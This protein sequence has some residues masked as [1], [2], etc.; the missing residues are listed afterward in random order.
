MRVIFVTDIFSIIEPMGVMQLSALLKAQGHETDICALEQGHTIDVIRAYKP[1]VIACSFMTTEAERFRIFVEKVR[2]AFPKMI[3]IAGGPHP[4]Y[5]SQIVD[6]WALDAVVVG[7]GDGIIVPLLEGLLGGQSVR[8][9]MNVHTKE[10]KNPQGHL[11]ADLDSLPFADRALVAH[12][13]PFKYVPMKSFFATRGCP[14]SCSYCFNSAFNAMHKGKGEILRRRSV[15]NLIV[16]MA[17]VKAQYRPDFVRF[18]DDTFVMKYD[19]WVEEFVEKYRQRVGIP[20]YC[21]INPNLVEEKL[22]KAL[23]DAG[24]YSVMMGIESGNE[25]VRRRVLGR[26]VSDQSIKKA[27]KFFHEFDIKVFSN[28][29]L[30][31]PET[32]L[33]DDLESLEFS[34]DCRPAYSGFTVFTPFPGTALGD[35]VRQKG[36][37]NATDTMAKTFPISMQAGSVLNTVTDRE[38]Q[39]HRNILILAP[40]ANLFPWMRRMIT[41]HWVYW[42]PNSFFDL[43]GFG[44][45]N[46]CNWRVF[47]FRIGMVGFVS[48]L[49]KVCRIDKGNYQDKGRKP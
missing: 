12:K 7:E 10:F 32:T 43:I 17:Q 38:R 31:L 41:R 1:Q 34:L 19:V 6:E 37:I 26:P 49:K 46:Y 28:T 25:S 27:F 15:E 8:S 35:Y 11:V 3:I 47:P 18:G 29:I 45:R 20:F 22:V 4:T 5:Y 48:L 16:E 33:K 44:V 40:V 14:Y 9:L 2:Q 24:C 30:A 13:E 39:I 42:R 36:Y 21:L 23:K